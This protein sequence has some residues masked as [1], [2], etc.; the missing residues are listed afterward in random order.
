VG[1]L[2]H[3]K[4]NQ[5]LGCSH[6]FILTPLEIYKRRRKALDSNQIYTRRFRIT[7]VQEMPLAISTTRYVML[8]EGFN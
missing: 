2:K 8:N 3:L 7:G 1:D 6:S 4:C 5:A